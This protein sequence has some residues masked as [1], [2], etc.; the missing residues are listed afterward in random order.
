MNINSRSCC[1][2][3]KK[4]LIIFVDV[5]LNLNFE[6]QFFFPNEYLKY[7]KMPSTIF[8]SSKNGF[9]LFNS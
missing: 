5:F 3:Y 2:K 8:N 1:Q 7:S 9:F 4:L 6:K